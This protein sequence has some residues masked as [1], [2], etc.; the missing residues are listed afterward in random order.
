MNNKPVKWQ[1]TLPRFYIKAWKND[2]NTHKYVSLPDKMVRYVR[3]GN[4]PKDPFAREFYYEIEG[5]QLNEIE[6]KLSKMEDKIANVL[7]NVLT[8]VNQFKTLQISEKEMMYLYFFIT[9]QGIRSEQYQDAMNNLKGDTLFKKSFE[10]S[11][12]EKNKKMQIDN[13]DQMYNTLFQDLENERDIEID[14]F[15]SHA[16][17]KS[18]EYFFRQ[19]TGMTYINIA[20][21]SD[22]ID[23]TFLT[24]EVI[25]IQL[26]DLQTR[27]PIITFVPISPKV[28][29]MLMNVNFYI[30]ENDPTFAETCGLQDGLRFSKEVF[31]FDVWKWRDSLKFKLF[32]KIDYHRKHIKQIIDLDKNSVDLINALFIS[33]KPESL[34]F[35]NEK[36][37]NDAKKYA[38]INNVAPIEEL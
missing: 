25:D 12:P 28:V 10:D 14:P 16:K 18:Y 23:A 8:R 15:I 27:V 24:S 11:D 32:S 26:V 19:Y 1:H 37:W 20:K 2:D 31:E 34:I 17:E 36:A 5:K 9:L 4:N 6:N 38:E 3:I 30:S 33:R 22:D 7:S 35:K 13:I 21:I 29:L